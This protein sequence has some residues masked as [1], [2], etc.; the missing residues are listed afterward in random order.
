M[1]NMVNSSDM[2]KRGRILV[3]GGLGFIGSHIT[4][5]LLRKGYS[6]K[7]FDKLYGSREL[8]SDIQE[9]VD[10]E[11]GDAERPEDVLRALKGVDVAI[12]LIHTTVPG[13]SMIDPAY[14]VQSNVV[15]HARWLQ[16]LDQTSLKKIIYISS[17]GT[18]YGLPQTNPI[19]EDHPTNPMSS[20]GITKLAIEKYIAM[21][22]KISGINYLICRP[23]NVYGEGQRLHT[24]QGVIGVFLDQCLKGEAIEIWGDGSVRRDYL[25]VSDMARAVVELIRYRRGDGIFN[26]SSGRGCSLNDIVAV[27]RDDLKIPIQVKY[28]TSRKFD[29]PVNVLDH[30]LL[31]RETGWRPETDLAVGVHCVYDYLRLLGV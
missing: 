3:L 21:Y 8:I 12:D 4:R 30:C 17:G 27:I 28:M 16:F 1:M 22:S 31:T 7:I 9:E 5:L 26:I 18:V 25:Y 15:A 20:Y 23:S 10:M 14:D 11:E 19:R 6:V 13:A 29:V 24:G 2:D